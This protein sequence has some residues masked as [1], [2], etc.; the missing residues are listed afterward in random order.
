M[1]RWIIVGALVAVLAAMVARDASAATVAQ[2][3]FG[4]S[5]ATVSG[6]DQDSGELYSAARGYGWTATDGRI[7]QCFTRTDPDPLKNSICR[8]DDYWDGA[9]VASPATWRYDVANGTYDVTVAVGDPAAARKHSVAVEGVQVHQ[10]P[11]TVHA[12]ASATVTVSD[13]ELTLTFL[14]DERTHLQWLRIESTTTTTTTTTTAPPTTTTTTTA[15]PSSGVVELGPGVHVINTPIVVVSGDLVAG[16][17]RGVTMLTPGPNLTGPM[18]VTDTLTGDGEADFVIRDLT[19][20]CENQC[21]GLRLHGARF[22]VTDVEVRR[23]AGVGL[24]TTWRTGAWTTSVTP[25]SPA[26][27]AQVSNVL[28]QQSGSASVA[29]V[30]IDG[31]HDSIITDLIVATHE[32]GA[33][34]PAAVEV[35]PNGFGTIFD[36]LHFWGI[37]HQNGLVIEPGATGV[38]A[39]NSYLEGADERQLWAQGANNGTHIDGRVQCFPAT[40]GGHGTTNIG[41]Q[42]DGATNAGHLVDAAIINCEGGGLVLNDGAGQIATFELT[43]WNSGTTPATPAGSRIE[44]AR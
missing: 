15:P 29:P 30:R 28:I 6:F 22:I 3:N 21:D 17:G 14:P 25:G 37:G 2:I 42:F 34:R 23:A 19:I 1:I 40:I 13:G 11:S 12:T 31:P 36:R 20:D 33:D 7:R 18:I 27:E 10:T 8:A 24:H 32:D 39:S 16:A 4:P 44:V 26:M 9:W 41:L 35:G 38:R 5:A 43:V